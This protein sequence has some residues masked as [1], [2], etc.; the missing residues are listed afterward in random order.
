MGKMVLESSAVWEILAKG[1]FF[2]LHSS[3]IKPGE[4]PIYRWHECLCRRSKRIYKKSRINE[5]SK[6]AGYKIY[7]NQLYVYIYIYICNEHL[8][9]KIKNVIPFTHTQSRILRCKSN[10]AYIGL[11]YWKLQNADE[12][13]QRRSIQMERHTVYMDGKT[14]HYK[15]VNSPQI[16]L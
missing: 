13:N 10:K 16:E 4:R 14:Q 9:T 11:A 5:F 12:I 15:D 6:V 8:S 3:Q 7:K 2:E 1:S